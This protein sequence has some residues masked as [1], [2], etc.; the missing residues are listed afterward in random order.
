M[1]IDLTKAT[2]IIPIRIESEDR[3]RNIITVVAFLLETFDT[4]IL[5]KEV[6]THSVFEEKAMPILHNIVDVDININHIFEKSDDKLFHRQR[7]INEMLMEAKTEVIFNYDSDVILPLESYVKS[8][9]SILDK[10]FDVVYPYE[11]GNFQKRV[12]ADDEVVSKFLM[13]KDYTDLDKYTNISTADAGWVQVFN[14]DVYIEGGMENENFK[15]YAPEDVE[16]LHRF[17][18]LGYKVGRI[19]DFVYHLEHGRSENSWFSNPHMASNVA[20]WEKIKV[21]NKKQLKHYYS[22]QKYLKKY[23]HFQI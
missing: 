4:N 10:T 7:I 23:N 17:T 13:T 12:Y 3:L 9:Q 18:T 8:Y 22:R 15:A 20:E 19:V 1:R 2:F 14:R 5:I 6:D 11:R 16:R 21:L